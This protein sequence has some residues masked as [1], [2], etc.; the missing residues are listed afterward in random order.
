MILFDKVSSMK[1]KKEIITA[2]RRTHDLSNMRDFLAPF[3]HKLL[4]KKAFAEADVL[5]H[6]PEIVGEETASYAKP[7]RIDFKKN[8]RTGGVL[9][10]ETAG[11]AFALEIQL[12]ERIVLEKVNTFFGYEAVNSLR[13][14]QNAASFG[15][16]KAPIHNF[17][18]TLVTAEEENYIESLSE[19]IKDKNLEQ[20][21]QK[22]GRAIVVDNK[23]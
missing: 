2:E 3:A 4:G 13:I 14:M 11:G 15:Q 16:T 8:E 23:K 12:K 20:A 1:D 19:G 5:C 7:L 10:I 22:L 21:L 9:W 17:E 18:K 6:W